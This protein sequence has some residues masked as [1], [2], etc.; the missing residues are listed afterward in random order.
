MPSTDSTKQPRIARDANFVVMPEWILFSDLSSHA[1]TVW[2]ALYSYADRQDDRAF[3]SRGKLKA[4]LRLGST[5]TVDRAIR[6]LIDFGALNRESREGTSSLYTVISQRPTAHLR[7]VPTAHVRQGVPHRRGTNKNQEQKPEIKNHLVADATE[8]QN[9]K[10]ERDELFEAVLQ[11]WLPDTD[12]KK[13]SDDERGRINRVLPQLR[14]LGA[15]PDDI[16]RRERRYRER[17]LEGE[18]TPQTL[19]KTWTTLGQGVATD[20]TKDQRK[21]TRDAWREAVQQLEGTDDETDQ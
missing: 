16:Y 19:T 3:P 11:V 4:D 1:K 7:Q 10:R 20:I 9:G 8:K 18:F 5:D 21:Q 6:E 12:P 13:L 15:T 17:G 14:K 2:C